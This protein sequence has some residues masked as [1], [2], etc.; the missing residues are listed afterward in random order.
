VQWIA[1]TEGDFVT[2]SRQRRWVV[3]SGLLALAVAI[4]IA[5]AGFVFDQRQRARQAEHQRIEAVATSIGFQLELP[6]G[7]VEP[8]D[9]RALSPPGRAGLGS[10][11]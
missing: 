9:A 5:A 3:R 10:L 4:L 1:P 8:R 6:D 11:C 7:K 2:R